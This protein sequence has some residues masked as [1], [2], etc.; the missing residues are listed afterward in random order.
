M[1][2]I[3]HNVPF[4]T[5]LDKIVNPASPRK[6]YHYGSIIAREMIEKYQPLV[7]IGGHMHEHFGKCTLGKTTCINAG[8]SG[9]VNTL[10][11]LEENKITKIQFIDRS[12]QYQKGIKR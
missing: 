11:E 7:C 3:S 6:G 8:F 2:F 4:N 9:K 1:L 12:G 10:L 5:S